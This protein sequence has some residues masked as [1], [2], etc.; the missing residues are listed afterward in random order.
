VTGPRRIW[1]VAVR[2]IR[3]RLRSPVFFLSLAV[4]VVAVLAFAL[5]PS[6]VDGGSQDVGLA[7]QVPPGLSETVLA[8][9]EAGDT[10]LEVRVFDTVEQG[11]Q[12]VRDGDVDVLVVDGDRLEWKRRADE[13][14]RALVTGAI[15]LVTVGERAGAA[16]I[17]PDALAAL[18][19]PAPV[20]NVELGQVAGRSADDELVTSVLSLVLFLSVS[21][22]GGMVLT[23]VIE[24]KSTRVVEVL[25]ARITPRDLLAGKVLGI[26][27]LGLVQV[28][29]TGVAALLAIGF[30][31]F[32]DVPAARASVIAWAVAW[33]VL[34]YALIATAYGVLGSLTSRSE[35]ASSVTGP[36]TVVLIGAYFVPFAT[37]GSPDAVWAR[38]ASWFPATA[39]FAMPNRIAMGAAAW[40]EPWLA[41]VL[42]VAAVVALVVLGGRVYRHAIL[43]T[44]GVL[45]LTDA[46]RGIVTSRAR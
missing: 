17:S 29:V 22:Y 15:Q 14:L 25:L 9:G 13:G 45:R 23:G 7:G 44:G 11:E 37:I 4:V 19:E 20:E 35:D 30:S 33:F 27:V 5:V 1:L 31:D 32:V 40:W 21:I 10:E 43:H 8:Q 42:T 3:E 26:G 36:L 41:V 6:L 38:A 24:E 46:W 28:A 2:E 34:G 18:V 39:P 16:G 12:A